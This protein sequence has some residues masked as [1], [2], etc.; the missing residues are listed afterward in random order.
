MVSQNLSW[1]PIQKYTEKESSWWEI[2]TKVFLKEDPM[3]ELIYQII[4]QSLKMN[5]LLVSKIHLYSLYFCNL[6]FINLKTAS[7]LNYSS[8]DRRFR[9]GVIKFIYKSKK[10]IN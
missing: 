10:E 7:I 1:L 4:H 8:A 6:L 9:M 2:I 5:E 3:L